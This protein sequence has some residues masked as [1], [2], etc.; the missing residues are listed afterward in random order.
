MSDLKNLRKDFVVC[1]REIGLR[2]N[3][4]LHFFAFCFKIF[5]SDNDLFGFVNAA[6]I[7]TTA[8]K[9]NNMKIDMKHLLIPGLKGKGLDSG[10]FAVSIVMAD[11]P[12]TV[13]ATRFV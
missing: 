12:P 11:A 13:D 5:I 8:V 9:Y 10:G 4:H 6:F 7:S 3:F 2:C 1:E